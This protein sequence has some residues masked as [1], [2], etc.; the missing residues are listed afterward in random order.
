MKQLKSNY[1]SVV[2]KFELGVAVALIIG[3]FADLGQTICE[4]II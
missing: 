3:L 2:N 1:R 4:L